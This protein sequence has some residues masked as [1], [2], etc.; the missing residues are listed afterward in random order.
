MRP[1]LAGDV[2]RCVARPV[3]GLLWR[4]RVSGVGNIPAGGAIIAA[5]HQSVIDS[6]FLGVHLPRPVVFI[7]KAE[8]LDSWKTRYLFP[9]LGMIPIDR[10]GGTS[11][12]PALDFG[13]D[14]LE[15]GRLL[16]VYPEGTRSRTG[17]LHKGRTG[18][19]RLAF[20]TGVPVVPVGIVGTRAIQPPDVACPR[21]F[22]RAE[23]RIGRPVSPGGYV[24]RV[25]RSLG[26]RA[27]T[28]DVMFAIREL[29]GLEYDP[30][31]AD[32]QWPGAD[33][34]ARGLGGISAGVMGDDR[35]TAR[36]ALG[37]ETT[38]TGRTAAVA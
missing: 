18:I 28:D 38:V 3:F 34:S 1:G 23:L 6:F 15:E 22:M 19:A 10:S 16:G 4:V 36:E 7:G 35:P 12:A 25:P 21:P 2:A 32:R 31:Y 30:T 37:A 9:A 5:N 27:M 24:D 14:L 13:A 20:R 11:S 26:L 33:G 17:R 8:Y 29:S